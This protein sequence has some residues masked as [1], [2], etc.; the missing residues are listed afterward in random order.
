MSGDAG[1]VHDPGLDL[2]HGK[3]IH[4]LRQDGARVQETCSTTTQ[5]RPHRAL[6]QLAPAQADTRPPQINVAEHQIG[7][8]QVLG[9]LTN[10][11]YIAA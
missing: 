10:E 6:G 8:R 2:R 9:G 5:P 7:R 1:D 4:A 11:Y 3:H